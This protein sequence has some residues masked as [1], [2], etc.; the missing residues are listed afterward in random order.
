[1]SI[2]PLRAITREILETTERIRR[3]GE[4]PIDRQ[5]LADLRKQVA[6]A[7]NRFFAEQERVLLQPLRRSGDPELTAIARGC[8]ERDLEG[9]QLGLRHYQRWTLAHI[10][11]DPAGYRAGVLQI[12][13]W[14]ETRLLY[15]EQTAYP[16]LARLISSQQRTPAT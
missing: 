14:M 11:A 1:M 5:Y 13:R 2:E 3:A 12:L 10:E 4:P 7:H 6:L 8:I 9:R 16:A 15:A